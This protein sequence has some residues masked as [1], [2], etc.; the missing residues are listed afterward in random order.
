MILPIVFL[1]LQF[2]RLQLPIFGAHHPVHLLMIIFDDFLGQ[3]TDRFYL[4]LVPHLLQLFG[5][6]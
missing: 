1:D 5:S 6:T 2:G 4:R 3:I